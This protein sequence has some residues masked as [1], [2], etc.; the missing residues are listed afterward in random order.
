MFEGTKTIVYS[1]DTLVK[2]EDKLKTT[3]SVFNWLKN[4]IKKEKKRKEEETEIE[5][6]NGNLLHIPLHHFHL[7]NFNN[8]S[9]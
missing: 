8:N 3:T 2:L 4:K 5:A 6:S 9:R 1:T 7:L